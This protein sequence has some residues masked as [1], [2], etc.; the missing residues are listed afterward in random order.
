MNVEGL[1][2]LV[3]GGLAVLVVLDPR[4]VAVGVESDTAVVPVVHVVEVVSAG[5]H[6][7]SW[8][9]AS[10]TV[11]RTSASAIPASVASRIMAVI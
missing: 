3:S 6:G 4:V 2:G 7:A 11:A 9:S 8:V 5:A 10:S 1:V